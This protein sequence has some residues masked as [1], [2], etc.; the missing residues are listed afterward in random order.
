MPGLSSFSNF[1]LNGQPPPNVTTGSSTT[2][3][4]PAWYNSYLSSLANSAVN[5]AGADYQPYSGQRIASMDPQQTQAYN[6][7]GSNA[8]SFQQPLTAGINAAQG[9][10]GGF[11]AGQFEN[12]KSPYIGGVVNE[13]QRLGLQNLNENLLPTQNSQFVE[14]GQFGSD[15]NATMNERLIRDTG[16]NISGQQGL[17]LQGSFQSAMQNY[18]QGQGQV[19]QAAN[20]LGGLAQA[21]Q[22]G[23]L[24][25]AGALS[26]SGQTM[27]QQ[28]QAGLDLQYQDYL[29]QINYPRQ[30][31]AFLSSALQGANIPT[32]QNT[33]ES[34][35]ASTYTASPLASFITGSVAGLTPKAARGGYVRLA[36][37]GSPLTMA[38][39]VRP[40]QR[41]RIPNAGAGLRMAGGLQ[42]LRM[43]A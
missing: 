12:Y 17:A 18:L 24:G 33:V 27:Q 5:I 2:G 7:L 23:V 15:R 19:N 36:A 39:M 10:A 32:S 4:L 43:A 34:K 11:D 25:A 16:A 41:K 37:G 22:A 21:Q 26:A 35:P 40:L 3:G 28:N 31:V 30:N 13:I 29:N 6:Y 20:N 14:A 42:H 38:S 9:V 8:G 1:L